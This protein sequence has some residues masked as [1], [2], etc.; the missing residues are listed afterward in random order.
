MVKTK[1]RL[2][3]PAAL[4]LAAMLVLAACGGSTSGVGAIPR[5]P[6]DAN[7]QAAYAPAPEGG[8]WSD[9]ADNVVPKEQAGGAG[10]GD[11]VLDPP[12]DGRKIIMTAQVDMET[13]DFLKTCADLQD[14]CRQAGGQTYATSIRSNKA[15]EA[16]YASF[17]FKIPP[18][19][20]ADFLKA[21]DGYGN[22]LTRNE[23]SDDVTSQYIDIEANLQALQTE[24]DRLLEMM[25]AAKKLEEL[26]ILQDRLTQLQ[27]EINYYTQSIRQLDRQIAFCTVDVSV[28]EVVIYT[29]P[30]EEVDN[31]FGARMGRAFS[32][33]WNNFVVFFQEL[34]LVIIW[35]LPVL[36]VAAVVVAIVLAAVKLH[37][38]YRRQHPKPVPPQPLVPPAPIKMGP[39]APYPPHPPRQAP[40]PARAMPLDGK[41]AAGPELNA[42]D[43]KSDT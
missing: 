8:M 12:Q 36:V 26:L 32:E 31:S 3:I 40:P 14:A 13:Q 23:Q 27:I 28:R 24:R 17:T 21:L 33:T 25:E 39:Y 20:Y 15:D 42:E 2:A 43:K 16:R 4:V 35:M 1:K 37:R 18:E 34:W 9:A 22:V 5:A 11:V 19:R 7:S 38:R 6:A 29:E 10:T 41:S 30:E